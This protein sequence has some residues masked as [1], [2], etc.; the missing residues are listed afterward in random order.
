MTDK[1][2]RKEFC[3]LQGRLFSIMQT[4]AH[5]SKPHFDG[6][7]DKALRYMEEASDTHSAMLWNTYGIRDSDGEIPET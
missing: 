2:I 6:D 1:E 4:L 3:L 5:I 7:F